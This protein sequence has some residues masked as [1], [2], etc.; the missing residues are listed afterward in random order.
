MR[1]DPFWYEIQ[2][3]RVQKI[4]CKTGGTEI[5]L[6]F[7]AL[8]FKWKREYEEIGRVKGFDE[9]SFVSYVTIIIMLQNEG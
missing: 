2:F 8:S 6:H 1:H 5:L 7:I 9:P 4:W 3:E